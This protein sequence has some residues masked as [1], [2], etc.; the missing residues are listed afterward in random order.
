M[1]KIFGGFRKLLASPDYRN[2]VGNFVYLSILKVISFVMPLIT[3]PYLA[4]VI[5][6]DKFGAIAFAASIVVLFQTITDWGFN[7]TATRDVAKHR[8]NIGFVS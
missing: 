2:L 4:T 6:V 7:Y 3:M 1:N 8:E 5:G